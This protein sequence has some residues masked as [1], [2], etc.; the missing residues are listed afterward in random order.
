M[1]KKERNKFSIADRERAVLMVL[2]QGETYHS[3]AKKLQT[4]A[5]LISRWV[6][7]Y[8]LHGVYG[9]SLKN[10]NVYGGDFKLKLI[11][12]M[13]ELGLS[14]SQISAKYRITI[15]VLS[16]WRRLYEQKG[17]SALYETKIRGR[18]P[19]MKKSNLKKKEDLSDYEELLK[20]NER[21]RIENDYLKKVCAL[22]Q[23]KKTQ[24]KGKKPRPS[25]N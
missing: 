9:L 18:P 15:S 6:N 11:L 10:N 13:Q 3:L 23:K 7:T 2:E 14:L 5:Q 20:E 19:K 22:I 16:G 21:L 8:K 24:N 4:S 25:K 1:N 12:E 17:V